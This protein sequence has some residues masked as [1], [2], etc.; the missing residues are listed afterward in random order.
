MAAASEAR[1]PALADLW[2][3]R[4]LELAAMLAE[5]IVAWREQL[6][7]DFSASAEL[8]RRFVEVHALNGFA[9]LVGDEAVGYAYYVCEEHKG[10]VGDLFV[11][12]EFRTPELEHRLLG[13]VVDQ[14]MNT[15]GVRRIESQ[16]MMAR[17]AHRRVLPAAHHARTHERNF[18]MYDLSRVQELPERRTDRVVFDH[19]TER[20]QDDAAQVIAVSYRG[21][22]DSEINDQYRSAEGARRFLFNIVQYPGCGAFFQPA[23]WVALDRSSGRVQGISLTSMVARG[24]GHVTQICTSPAVR[25]QGVG[26]ELLRRSLASLAEGGAAKASLTVTTGNEHAVGLYERVGFE[27]LRRFPAFVWEGF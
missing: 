16:L 9:L 3:V 21:H 11:R 22:I 27:T 24:V 7:W 8:V 14:L 18:M 20:R 26:Y 12:E 13:A 6:D 15:G 1:V 17:F 25:G 19:W 2:Q 5:E 10:L 23:S 4:P